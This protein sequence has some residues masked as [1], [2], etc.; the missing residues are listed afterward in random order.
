VNPL[1]DAGAT[2][3]YDEFLDLWCMVSEEFDAKSAKT[4]REY[5]MIEIG[6]AFLQRA[7]GQEPQA[8]LT[9]QFV[10]AY[11][12][13]WNKGVRYLP[14]LSK[15]LKRLSRRY[16]LGLITNTSDSDFVMDHLQRIGVRGL[17]GA[18]VTSVDF[19]LRKPHPD[20]FHFAME[21]GAGSESSAYVGDSF[22]ADYQGALAAGT[23]PFLIDPKN[24]S[25]VA[26]EVRLTSLF[27]LERRIGVI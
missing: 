19:G 5:S 22:E 24:S 25:P 8:Q 23:R 14:G 12:A 27:D 2:H 21:A 10:N 3:S 18:V 1:K 11:L 17:F 9:S 26:E 13:E 16:T 4:H 20:I 15:F 6:E 7:F